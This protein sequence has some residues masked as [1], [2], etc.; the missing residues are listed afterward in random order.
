MLSIYI[1][2]VVPFMLADG[3]RNLFEAYQVICMVF[4]CEKLWKQIVFKI[5]RPS[6]SEY[7]KLPLKKN[8]I[9]HILNFP[10]SKE[11]KSDVEI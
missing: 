1:D 5:E 9:V 3:K 8:V 6:W 4:H 7:Q 2:G 11:R 10:F